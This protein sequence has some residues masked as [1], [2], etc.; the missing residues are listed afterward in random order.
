M[1][2]DPRRVEVGRRNRAKWKGFTPAG[3]ERLRQSA[4]E[5]KPWR[6]ATGP[7]TAQGR[8][9]VAA[10]GR[11]RCRGDVSIPQARAEV[12]RANAL[13]A[14]LAELTRLLLNG[15]DQGLAHEERGLEP[16]LHFS[17]RG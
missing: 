6:F 5:H 4:L 15:S 14:D 17:S 3:L 11:S 12:A 8:L 7:R 10:N 2:P 9:I 13:L 1:P 16:A